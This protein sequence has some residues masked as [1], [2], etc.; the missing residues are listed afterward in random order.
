MLFKK[1]K[2][3]VLFSPKEEWMASSES[4]LGK[5]RKHFGHCHLLLP[6]QGQPEAFVI[7]FVQRQ[8]IIQKDFSL[9]SSEDKSQVLKICAL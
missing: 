4:L 8:P 7:F 2:S 9:L 6:S 1:F 3:V 5:L